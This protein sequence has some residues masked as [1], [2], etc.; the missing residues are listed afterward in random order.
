MGRA[1]RLGG[2]ETYSWSSSRQR[3]LEAAPLC[4]FSTTWSTGTTGVKTTAE[5]LEQV[6]PVGT[7]VGTTRAAVR[8]PIPETR[9]LLLRTGLNRYHWAGGQAHEAGVA[10]FN[11]T[12]C[13][14][15]RVVQRTV[16]IEKQKHRHSRMSAL[17][18]EIRAIEA[19]AR[20]GT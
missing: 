17:Y 18:D 10:L 12:R 20:R 15:D 5:S 11:G 1:A 3:E 2:Y 14:T 8:R 13:S 9:D 19:A 7:A 6:D 4:R 16:A